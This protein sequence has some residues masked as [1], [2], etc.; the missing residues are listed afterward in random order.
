MKRK[1]IKKKRQEKITEIIDIASSVF[2]QKG[3]NGASTNEIA[4]RIGVS[5]RT[6]Y[7]YAGDKDNL[8]ESVIKKLTGEAMELVELNPIKKNLP[9]DEKLKQY[10]KG[11][12]KIG[13]LRD[14]HSI[15]LRELLYNENDVSEDI[16]ETLNKGLG[17]ICEIV[18][19][20]KEKGTFSK[21]V[22]PLI[23]GLMTLSFFI[24]WNLTIPPLYKAGYFKEMIEELGVDISDNLV[25]EVQKIFST[26]LLSK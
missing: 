3:Y 26:L 11:V 25:A 22:N 2:S 10:I 16:L 14:L 8:Y 20:G 7:Y 23:L 12:S 21:E 15:A 13:G 24:Y 4:D 1:D 6:M 19:E 9:N 5:K 17:V 18:D